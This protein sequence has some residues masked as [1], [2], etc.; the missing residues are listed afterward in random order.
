MC[1]VLTW[2][3]GARFITC[4]GGLV[5]LQGVIFKILICFRE[6]SIT[7]GSFINKFHESSTKQ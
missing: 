5:I 7:W 3:I 1:A 2:M 4:K 6:D